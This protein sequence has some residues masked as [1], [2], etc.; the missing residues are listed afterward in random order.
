[1]L[2][3][4]LPVELATAAR[5]LGRREGA[6][7]FMVLLAAL[8]V[9]LRHAS[10]QDDLVLGTDLAHRG[11]FETEEL[12]GFFVNQ[13]P[14]RLDL[15]GDPSVAALLARVREAA[16]G[17]FSPPRGALRRI[18]DAL[19]LIP[20]PQSPATVSGEAR[21]AQFPRVPRSISGLDWTPV[22][23]D[24]GTA[25]FDLMLALEEGASGLGGGSTTAPPSRSE[26]A[27]SV[28][29]RFRIVLETAVASP[30]LRLSALAGALA[31]RAR[32]EREK[33]EEKSTK[34]S[35]P[36][37]LR[38]AP[39]AVRLPDGDL[40]TSGSCSRAGDYRCSSSR[41]SPISTQ[42]NGRRATGS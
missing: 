24:N 36:K 4:A 15:A 9:V 38:Q 11:S 6:T 39:K 32:E 1:M 12:I 23:L 8:A 37:F 31:Q 20:G 16:L 22:P 34:S 25:Q 41:R 2:P 14:L 29:E 28:V 5:S 19:K 42:W 21:R 33:M 35:P 10:G 26:T 17:A 40:V 30:E 7:V 13:L 27:R 3:V 18:V